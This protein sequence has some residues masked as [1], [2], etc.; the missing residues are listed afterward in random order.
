MN[1]YRKA[2]FLAAAIPLLLGVTSA[3]GAPT[4]STGSL[5]QVFKRIGGAVVVVRTSERVVARN[6]QSMEKAVNVLGI[7]S[8]VLITADGKVM[9]AAHV[10]QTAEAVAAKLNV[11]D[12]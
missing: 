7:G 11:L 12:R 10:V 4:P 8:G 5:S 2:S 9:T 1:L 3:F 6:S